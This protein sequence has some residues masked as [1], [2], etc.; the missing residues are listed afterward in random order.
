M[1]GSDKGPTDLGSNRQRQRALSRWENE[2]GAHDTLQGSLGLQ[3][4]KA[5]IPELTNTELVQ[6]RIRVIALENLM[7]TFLAEASH[8]QLD[9]AR[10]MAAFI[11]PRPGSEEHP[12][13]VHAANQMVHLI[14]R[15]AHFRF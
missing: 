15:A 3:G 4:E 13:T 6:L 1:I 11:S 12:L 7:I 2:G 5:G 8:R 14:D 10:E 9:L